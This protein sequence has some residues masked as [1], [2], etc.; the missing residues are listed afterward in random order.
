MYLHS[1]LVLLSN[2]ILSWS[3]YSKYFP[4]KDMSLVQC[5]V[6]LLQCYPVL[7]SM[8]TAVR[9]VYGGYV[10]VPLLIRWSQYRSG[11]AYTAVLLVRT[12]LISVLFMYSKKR[13]NADDYF[14][15]QYFRSNDTFIK[16]NSY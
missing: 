15:P 14:S 5:C 7:S 1:R 13:Q 6:I 2:I 8:S 3:V 4:P 11:Y 12:S 9:Y 10:L 16:N